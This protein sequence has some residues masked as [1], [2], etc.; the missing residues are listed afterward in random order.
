MFKARRYTIDM[1]SD[2]DNLVDLA[3]NATFMLKR[4]YMDY[5]SDRFKDHSLV[6]EKDDKLVAVFP[7]NEQDTTIQSHGGLSFGGIVY[8]TK[9]RAKEILEVLTTVLDYYRS[10]NFKTLQYKAVPN[11]YHKYPAEEVEYALFRLGAVLYRRDLSS[12]F[13][14]KAPIKLSKGRRWLLARGKKQNFKV[15]NSSNFETFFT[16]YTTHLETKY[17]TRPVHTYQ[18]MHLLKSR[19]EDNIHFLEVQDENGVFMGGSILYIS[20]MVVHAQYIH[21]TDEAK[22]LGAFDILMDHIRKEYTQHYFDFGISTEDNGTVLN[23]GLISFK[24]SFGG[25]GTLCNFYKI[26][27]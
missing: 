16:E 17:N 24:E 1:K 20:D 8:T 10:S 9:L 19:F 27:L 21:F 11:I 15:V 7:A 22:D 18:E 4:D 26:S 25:R 6:I 3:K 5:H 12:S 23:E 14:L 2:W 13:P